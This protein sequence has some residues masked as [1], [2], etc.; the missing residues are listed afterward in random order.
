MNYY[1]NVGGGLTNNSNPEV[2]YFET[3][4]KAKALIKAL[5]MLEG[6]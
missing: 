2:E 6:E 3:L 1:F 4:N 5:I